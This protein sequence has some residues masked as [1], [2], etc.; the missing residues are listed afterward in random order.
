[1]DESTHHTSLCYAAF[2]YIAFPFRLYPFPV[3]RGKVGYYQVGGIN[4]SAVIIVKVFKLSVHVIITEFAEDAEIGMVVGMTAGGKYII[5]RVV[6]NNLFCNVN[7][8]S[9]CNI[10]DIC[11][12]HVV[13]GCFGIGVRGVVL[14]GA[15]GSFLG[16]IKQFCAG[17]SH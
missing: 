13:D 17:N 14:E 11:S 9:V 10:V 3:F 16:N 4:G 15:Q 8:D 12:I 2:G 1:M 6:E 7:A 5:G